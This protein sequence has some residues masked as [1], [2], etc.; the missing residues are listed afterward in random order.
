MR[1]TDDI[2]RLFQ[3]SFEGF[4]ATPPASVK[5]AID[6]EIG[7]KN[8]KMWWLL[9]IL[10]LL[11]TTI[12]LG[13]FLSDN[14]TARN[15]KSSELAQA[16]S[17]T[18]SHSENEQDP[19]NGK[20]KGSSSSENAEH[21]A[22]AGQKGKQTFITKRNIVQKQSNQ[23]TVSVEHKSP[24]TT[25]QLAGNKT[26]TG[27][28]GGDNKSEKKS[29]S[30]ANSVGNSS[31]TPP[32]STTFV[33]NNSGNNG[34][35]T[36]SKN[37]GATT[38]SDSTH[39]ADTAPKDSLINKIP[40]STEH[41]S[42]ASTSN[43]PPPKS[44]TPAKWMASLYFGPQFDVQHSKYDYKSLKAAPSFRPSLEINRSLIAG[45]GLTTGIGYISQSERYRVITYTM[46]S[47]FVGIDS[48]AI[49]DQQNPDSIIGYQQVNV[50]ESDTIEHNHDLTSKVSTVFI[51]IYV[52]KH[53]EFNENWGLLVNAG[54]VFR[55]SSITS[56]KDSFPDPFPTQYKTGVMLSGRIQGTYT[57]GNWMFS[58]GINGGYYLK[59]PLGYYEFNKP[60]YFISPQLGIHYRF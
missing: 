5:T 47:V 9:A 44:D 23:Y 8:R 46:D 10:F 4:E 36:T 48:I 38:T 60:R 11:T 52:T 57:K 12:A 49:Y 28:I 15:K 30:G 7:T 25:K 13:L 27:R 2:E 39:T 14:N 31:G 26:K 32:I 59:P 37:A 1:E 50:Y 55:I 34:N 43:N 22:Q 33:N 16:E 51:P 20:F 41:T 19:Q 56:P 6:H 17:S 21:S 40:D 53:F 29:S 54:A 45:Y 3:E 58:A 24:K 35:N 42:V 18:P